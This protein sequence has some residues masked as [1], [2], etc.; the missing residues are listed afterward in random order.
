MLSP[1]ISSSI[2]KPGL[3]VLSVCAADVL[4]LTSFFGAFEDLVVNNSTLV[5]LP[6]SNPFASLENGI[7]PS[8]SREKMADVK[9]D[10]QLNDKH[11]IWVRY[12]YDTQQLGGAKTA[13]HDVG[14][15]LVLGTSSTDSA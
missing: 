13:P 11:A 6:A 3:R 10:H 7:F 2:M 8:P 9:V 12:A 4:K 15:G 5:S 14:G 1:R